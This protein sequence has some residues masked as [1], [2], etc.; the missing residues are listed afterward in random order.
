MKG[1]DVAL[2]P[3]VFLGIDVR[4]HRP[5]DVFDGFSFVTTMLNVGFHFGQPD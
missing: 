3:L 2:V 5:V 1:F 4:Y